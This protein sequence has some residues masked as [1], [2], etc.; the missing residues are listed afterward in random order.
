MSEARGSVA[1]SSVQLATA[2]TPHESFASF[3]IFSCINFFLLAG[4]LFAAP[5][6]L[7]FDLTLGFVMLF[8]AIGAFAS[9]ATNFFN[10]RELP[11]FLPP[12]EGVPQRPHRRIYLM[13]TAHHCM[14][15]VSALIIYVLFASELIAGPLFPEFECR[16]AAEC[17]TL[18]GVMKF[19]APEHPKDYM[20]AFVWGF[21]SGFAETY[22]TS[23]VS[24]I[25]VARQRSERLSS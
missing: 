9:S 13:C 7:N 24:Q 15:A 18:S 1:P 12:G 16:Q 10:D 23:A 17:S 5:L 21:V 4:M 25:G 2:L 6:V 22:I 14:G 20:K 19:W 11:R 8:G 3:I